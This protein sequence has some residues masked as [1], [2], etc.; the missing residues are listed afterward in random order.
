MDGNQKFIEVKAT[1]DKVGK[2]KIY[3]SHNEY[4]VAKSKNN[5]Y[6]YIVFEVGSKK[7]KIWRIKALD[8][9]EDPNIELE[10]VQYQI[11]INSN[12]LA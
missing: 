3:I 10:P 7:P 6:F 2:N 11:K 1:L 4:E 9:L 8:F 5:Y 12:Q